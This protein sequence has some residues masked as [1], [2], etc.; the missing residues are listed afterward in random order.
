MKGASPKSIGFLRSS[1]G[2]ILSS[3]TRFASLA[4]VGI[5]SEGIADDTE[6]DEGAPEQMD[7]E[8]QPEEG[9]QS[10]CIV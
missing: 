8:V 1:N 7:N 4:E 5:Q 6:D 9:G 3:R 10:T 2:R